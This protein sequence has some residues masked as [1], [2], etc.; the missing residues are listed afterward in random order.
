MTLQYLTCFTLQQISMMRIY[1]IFHSTLKGILTMT[2][3]EF[4]TSQK[5][6][7]YDAI[8]QRRDM[9]SFRSDPVPEEI[10][11]RIL[12]AANEA[13]S[14]GFMQP[15]NFIL[16]E[17]NDLRNR[18]AQHVDEQRLKAANDFEG[19]RREHYL[20]FKLEGILEAPINMCI[21]CDRL[22][23]GPKVLGRSTILNTDVYSTCLAVQNLWLAA[24]AEGVGVG[25]VSI[26]EEETL[27]ELLELPEH[28][29]PVAYLC[30]GYVEDFPERPL[31]ESV[32]WLPKIPLEDQV[33]TNSWL[34]TDPETQDRFA[35]RG[36]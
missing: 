26:F 2:P 34:H 13:P 36:E 30:I 3:H 17:Q 4:E 15:W 27:S 9:R 32:N 35:H 19:E 18:I 1:K 33:Y 28:V 6:G 20:S 22:R 11:I 29:I 24:R 8:F 31:L 16:V 21:T 25:W 12:H 23:N 14:V 7:V 10:L 5:Q